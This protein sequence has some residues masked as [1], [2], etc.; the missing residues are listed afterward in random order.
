MIQSLLKG[1][2]SAVNFTCI[3]RHLTCNIEL[4]KLRAFAKNEVI[5]SIYNFIPYKENPRFIK[6]HLELATN[7]GLI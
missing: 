7:A 3:N 2:Q 5:V 1:E 6:R 4:D